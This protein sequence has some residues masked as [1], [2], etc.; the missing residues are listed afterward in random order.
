MKREDWL[1][2]TPGE[3]LAHRLQNQIERIDRLQARYGRGRQTGKLTEPIA[4]FER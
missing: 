4:F 1:R 3:K 2:L